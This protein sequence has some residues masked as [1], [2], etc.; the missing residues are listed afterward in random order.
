MTT[1]TQAEVDARIR[2]LAPPPPTF[3]PDGTPLVSAGHPMLEVIDH[4]HRAI[5]DLKARVEKVAADQ[6]RVNYEILQRLRALGG[7]DGTPPAG[8]S[9]STPP[10]NQVDAFFKEGEER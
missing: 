9:E 7:N 1:M 3:L 8:V 5:T 2:A 4:F 6:A 10:V